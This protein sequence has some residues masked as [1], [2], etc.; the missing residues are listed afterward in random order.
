M[1]VFSVWHIEKCER[2]GSLQSD[3]VSGLMQLKYNKALDP[4]WDP[5]VETLAAM[6]TLSGEYVV[7]Q[8]TTPHD[9]ECGPYVQTH[10]E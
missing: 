4:I 3:D 1:C 9:G 5:L 10:Q 8:V 2:S 6:I 7:L